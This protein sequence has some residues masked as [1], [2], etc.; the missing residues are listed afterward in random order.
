MKLWLDRL[1]RVG[2]AV[3]VGL[4]LQPWWGGGMRY[5]FFAA[6]VFTLLHIATSHM[7]LEKP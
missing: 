5:G 1:A 4:M 7:D 2:M 3:G 6:A